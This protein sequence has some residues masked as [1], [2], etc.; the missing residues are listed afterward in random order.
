[1]SDYLRDKYPDLYEAYDKRE[2]DK[3]LRAKADEMFKEISPMRQALETFDEE[4][5]REIVHNV[6]YIKRMEQYRRD[7]PRLEQKAMK[8]M[9]EWRKTT[10]PY[11]E[12]NYVGSCG[13]IVKNGQR[14]YW[15]G[16]HY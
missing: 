11:D 15:C 9:D 8:A 1:M 2:G 14:V 6:A 3:K 16:D 13:C 12:D 5:E 10:P 4:E 7:I